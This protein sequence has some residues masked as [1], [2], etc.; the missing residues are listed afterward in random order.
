MAYNILKKWLCEKKFSISPQTR[1]EVEVL[2]SAE[3]A[4]GR[5]LPRFNRCAAEGA[6][7]DPKFSGF[8]RLSDRLV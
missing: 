4:E 7:P 1:K 3:T 6:T 2:N 8:S 5:S